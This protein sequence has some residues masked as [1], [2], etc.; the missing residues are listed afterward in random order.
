V[1]RGLSPLAGGGGSGQLLETRG[2][3]QKSSRREVFKIDTH[4]VFLSSISGEQ[5]LAAIPPLPIIRYP[6][7]EGHITRWTG[8]LRFADKSYLGQGYSRVRSPEEVL[9]P[10]GKVTAYR[11]DTVLVANAGGRQISVPMARWF[12]PGI[13]MIRQRFIVGNFD[14]TKDTVSYKL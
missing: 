1:V 10:Q 8:A 14:V 11:V 13:G 2:E 4:G 3:N 9:L 6:I 7:R 5:S 12:A